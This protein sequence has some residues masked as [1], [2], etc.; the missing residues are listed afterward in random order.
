MRAGQ[1]KM[2]IQILEP[3]QSKTEVHAKR[4]WLLITHHR[5]MICVKYNT[6]K[7]NVASKMELDGSGRSKIS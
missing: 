2:G 1:S 3:Y 4:P 6:N 5:A 7:L